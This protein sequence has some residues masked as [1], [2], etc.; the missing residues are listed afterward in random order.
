MQSTVHV[1]DSDPAF[2][3]LLMGRLYA[4]LPSVLFHPVG[5][6]DLHCSTFGE[7]DVILYDSTICKLESIP[8]D[9]RSNHSPKSI[10]LRDHNRFRRSARELS[11]AIRNELH[12]SEPKGDFSCN[13]ELVH[14]GRL[15]FFIS[16]SDFS[17]RETYISANTT[18][19]RNNMNFVYR[20]NLMPGIRM[21]HS[22]FEQCTSRG[23]ERSASGISELLLRL[24]GSPHNDIILSSYVNLD[25]MGFHNF[26]RPVRSDDIMD[27]DVSVLSSLIQL[28]R[29]EVDNPANKLSAVVVLEGLSFSKLESLCPMAHEIHMILPSESESEDSLFKN[30]IESL[31]QRLP[32]QQLKFVNAS[33]RVF[34]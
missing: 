27:S 4:H 16:L 26:G 10:C 30:E 20:L 31:F 23:I 17:K 28:I 24:S 2:S 8:G 12:I 18:M 1:I 33:E 29:K 19:L 14:R 32:P 6:D 7:N 21:P 25:E 11:E 22:K 34:A 5:K 9:I 3:R 13:S 15:V